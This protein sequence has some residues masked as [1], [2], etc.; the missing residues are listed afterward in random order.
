MTAS[1]LAPSADENYYGI[2]DLSGNTMEWMQDCDV[3][4]RR[5]QRSGTYLDSDPALQ[6][7][8]DEPRNSWPRSSDKAQ[9]F[10]VVR[11][12]DSSPTLFLGDLNCDGLINNG[13][14]DPFVLALTDTAA[15]VLIFPDCDPYLADCNDDGWINNA[16][17][18]PFVELLT[19]IE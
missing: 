12:P 3:D 15:Y 17:I 11:V 1:I 19:V 5:T 9:G 16:D 7:R 4:G 8:T 10:R 13:D 14:I 2:F 18:D 6:L